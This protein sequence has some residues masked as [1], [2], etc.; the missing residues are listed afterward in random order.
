M[1]IRPQDFDFDPPRIAVASPRTPAIDQQERATQ[2][3]ELFGSVTGKTQRSKSRVV[4]FILAAVAAL[5][6]LIILL[7]YSRSLARQIGSLRNKSGDARVENQT[8]RA[9]DSVPLR[10]LQPEPDPVRHDSDAENVKVPGSGSDNQKE[11]VDRKSRET[12]PTQILRQQRE[13]EQAE[14]ELERKR[15]AEAQLALENQ[16]QEEAQEAERAKSQARQ[17]ELEQ[18]QRLR[19]AE[20]ALRTKEKETTQ[21]ETLPPAYKGPSS[22]T[23]VWEGE[24]NDADLIDIR[25]G[26]PNRGSLSGMLPGVPVM[27]QASPV[28]AVVI[29]IPPAPSNDWKRIVLRVRTKGHKKVTVMVRWVLP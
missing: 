5:F 18:Q 17:E 12:G 23:L 19:N 29:S 16:R 11:V 20:E 7:L 6:L 26:S 9:P 1:P 14:L 13:R 15:L 2:E 27:V 25:N 8:P 4:L 22:G 24:V 28:D 3:R 10:P 21:V